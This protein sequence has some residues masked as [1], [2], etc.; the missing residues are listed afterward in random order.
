MTI[1]TYVRTYVQHNFSIEG[2]HTGAL[3]LSLSHDTPHNYFTKLCVKPR[4]ILISWLNFFKFQKPIK[5]TLASNLHYC[6]PQF[7]VNYTWKQ[8]HRAHSTAS[9]DSNSNGKSID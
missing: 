3:S 4:T 2:P 6:I 8:E 7:V 5:S 1:N 9:V